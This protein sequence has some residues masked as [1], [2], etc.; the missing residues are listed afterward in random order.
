MPQFEPGGGKNEEPATIEDYE[1]VLED[2]ATPE[3]IQKVRDA[4]TNEYSPL[5]LELGDSAPWARMA[6]EEKYGVPPTAW[7]TMS[8]AEKNFHTFIDFLRIKRE[9]GILQEQEVNAVVESTNV[10]HLRVEGSRPSGYAMSVARM[11]RALL[12]IRPDLASEV[13]NLPIS[14]NRQ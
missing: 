11:R 4:L 9:A 8:S 14:R 2:K 6:V 7:Q 12:K 10:P 1:M 3:Q 13:N 5:Y